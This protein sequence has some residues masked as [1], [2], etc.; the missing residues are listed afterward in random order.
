MK[1]N[2][3]EE[4]MGNLNPFCCYRGTTKENFIPLIA[5]SH[6]LNLSTPRL[7]SATSF[8]SSIASSVKASRS[9]KVKKPIF[10]CI[11]LTL[12]STSKQHVLHKAFMSTSISLTGLRAL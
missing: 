11:H 8:N 7:N 1:Q 6:S 12:N 10:F 5:C 2:K 3:K 4:E 9:Q